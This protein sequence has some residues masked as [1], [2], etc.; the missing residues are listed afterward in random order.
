MTDILVITGLSGA[1]RSHAADNLEDLGW[2]MVDNLPM[3]L[4][5]K[6]VELAS[7][8]GGKLQQLGLV[9]GIGGN[10]ADLTNA[11][12]SLKAEGHRVRLLFLDAVTSELVKRYAETRR[13]HPLDDGSSTL[14]SLIEQERQLLE[15]VKA[16]A[17]IVMNTTGM[18]IHQLKSRLTETFGSSE[19]SNNLQLSLISFGFKQ[20]VPIDVDMVLDVRFLPNPH[21]LDE[22]RPLTG[23]DAAV[24]AYVLDSQLAQDFLS[25]LYGLFE[26]LLPAFADEGKSYLSV[27]IGCT[28]GR[29]RSV[30]IT[31]QFA[32]WLR[33]HGW[34][35]RVTHRELSSN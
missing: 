15:P 32:V 6:V 9:V 19:E 12:M 14:A 23:N 5:P 13:R 10:Q 22:L 16:M 30:A 2:F 3:E 31:N 20:G 18:N 28:G 11:I 4:I 17:D 21:W 24:G 1:G 26:V 33:S 34:S 25:R 7:A 29:H 27:A 35:P 8:Q